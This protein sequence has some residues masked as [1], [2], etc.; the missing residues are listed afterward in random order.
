MT[1][2]KSNPYCT[3]HISVLGFCMGGDFSLR[4]ACLL[5]RDIETCAIFYGRIPDVELVDNL[6]ADD[7]LLRARLEAATSQPGGTLNGAGAPVPRTAA[8]LIHPYPC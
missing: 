6:S 2:T 3:G 8:C 1:R 5:P 7:G 4:A